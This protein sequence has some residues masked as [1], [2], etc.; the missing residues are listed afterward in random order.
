MNLGF[1]QIGGSGGGSKTSVRGEREVE[2][3]LERQPKYESE[4]YGLDVRATAGLRTT[5]TPKE[6]PDRAIPT[7]TRVEETEGPIAVLY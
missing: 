1:F 5:W 4:V 3:T 2:L 6:A 7:I